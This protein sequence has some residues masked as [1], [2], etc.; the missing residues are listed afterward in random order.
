MFTFCYIM[1]LTD[2]NQIYTNVRTYIQTYINT[3]IALHICIYISTVDMYIF[4]VCV[5]FLT[6]KQSISNLLQYL[7]YIHTYINT[8]IYCVYISTVCIQYVLLMFI[9]YYV[10]FLTHVKRLL[11]IHVIIFLLMY[12]FVILLCFK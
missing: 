5:Y 6:C 7:T 1:F 11:K 8:Y 2:A 3:Y 12:I 4:T 9:L 10:I